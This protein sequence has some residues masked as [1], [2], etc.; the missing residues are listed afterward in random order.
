MLLSSAFPTLKRE[1]IL[2][3]D[4]GL[5]RIEWKLKPTLSISINA[6]VNCTVSA[7]F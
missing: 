3:V 6:Y 2:P 1:P 4:I 7:T 5:A